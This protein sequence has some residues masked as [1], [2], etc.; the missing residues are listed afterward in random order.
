MPH[1]IKSPINV[2]D[3]DK[4]DAADFGSLGTAENLLSLRNF[5]CLHKWAVFF[6]L[7]L[8]SFLLSTH[9]FLVGRVYF[10]LSF[11]TCTACICTMYIYTY[12]FLPLV[13]DWLN[14]CIFY[15]LHI[16]RPNLHPL[17]SLHAPLLWFVCEYGKCNIWI[18]VRA[19]KRSMHSVRSV[20][21]LLIQFH[22]LFTQTLMNMHLYS[23][24]CIA[25]ECK[26]V[27]CERSE[28]LN[29]RRY[30]VH[31]LVDSNKSADHWNA[32]RWNANDPLYDISK[33]GKRN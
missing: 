1:K 6:D 13:N 25:H 11:V 27:N 4:F 23:C 32:Q 8:A 14:D 21:S 31:I 20:R 33:D 15:T 18:S 3:W 29:N 24:V 2:R 30:A 22:F 12:S 5:K 9:Y 19:S 17:N 10:G 7:P 26:N 28:F 16:F